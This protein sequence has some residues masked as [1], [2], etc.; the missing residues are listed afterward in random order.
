MTEQNHDPL[1]PLI[2][3]YISASDNDDRPLP[4][5][6]IVSVLYAPAA[7][8]DYAAQALQLRAMSLFDEQRQLLTQLMRQL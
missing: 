2:S 6:R 1:I 8:Q 4:V 3:R 5:N 7:T